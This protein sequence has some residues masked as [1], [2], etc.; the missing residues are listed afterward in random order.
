MFR[1]SIEKNTQ[2]NASANQ[3]MSQGI[4]ED[5]DFAERLPA[6]GE[7]EEGETYYRADY[8]TPRNVQEAV[9]YVQGIFFHPPRR[10]WISG[11]LHEVT[12]EHLARSRK[13][14]APS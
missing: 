11:D 10:V 14:D 2:V 12:D 3:L 5:R 9:D 4:S 6:A 7:Y 13:P 8:E 1:F